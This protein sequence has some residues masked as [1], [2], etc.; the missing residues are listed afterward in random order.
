MA[1][2]KVEKEILQY[3]LFVDSRTRVVSRRLSQRAAEEF[4]IN[5]RNVNFDHWWVWNPLFRDW[6]PLKNIVDSKGDN[7][8]MLVQ[9]PE[10][11]SQ[12]NEEEDDKTEVSEH[13]QIPVEYSEVRNF[14]REETVDNFRD[15]HGDDL[16]ISGVPKPPSLGLGNDRRNSNRYD[17]KLEVLIAAKGKSFRTQ[18]I[19]IS[20]TGVML[21]KALP[22]DMFGGPFEI[23]F[24]FQNNGAKKQIV[25]QGKVSGDLKDRRR[26]VF[27]DLTPNNQK[28][29]EELFVA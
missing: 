16:T 20:L 28:L 12:P 13:T 5:L 17:K 19:N 27:G 25:F 14:L 18:T 8:R 21:E 22:F 26:L 24:Y 4:I 23:V 15:F 6:I 7:I 2:K 3:W 1:K 29:L 11:S 9:L 10:V